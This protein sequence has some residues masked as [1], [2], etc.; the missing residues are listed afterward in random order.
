MVLSS[1][2]KSW[3]KPV[4]V[5]LCAALVISA[6][7]S[8]GLFE[9]APSPQ[10][11]GSLQPPVSN[12][13]SRVQA[14]A[15]ARAARNASLAGQARLL[16]PGLEDFPIVV[17]PGAQGFLDLQTA[18]EFCRRTRNSAMNTVLLDEGTYVG[19]FTLPPSGVT[20][21]GRYGNAATILMGST[22]AGQPTLQFSPSGG[23]A[24]GVSTT[25]SG[26][27]IIGV[28]EAAVDMSATNADAEIN[29]DHCEVQSS[30]PFPGVRVSGGGF[31]SDQ[32]MSCYLMNSTIASAGDGILAN[33][34]P[35]S[36]VFA[37]RSFIRCSATAVTMNSSSTV[38]TELILA[39]TP[40]E[41]TA[42]LVA[43]NIDH[44]FSGASYLSG[45]QIGVDLVGVLDASLERG[46][47][48]SASGS[49]IRVSNSRLHA[50]YLQI[51]PNTAGG[52]GIA[53]NTSSEVN[54]A[55]CEFFSG[56]SSEAIR[57][58]GSSVLFSVYNHW[59]Y[60]PL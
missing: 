51:S 23:A 17:Y 15:S 56:L 40:V 27:T 53:A 7:M 10:A 37:F 22:G 25:L 9:L 58:D 49:A 57:I 33:T 2:L 29:I 48:H 4:L 3:W 38:E 20:V 55:F 13:P 54:A 45:E 50:R 8:H 43:S 59:Q 5:V 41:G 12:P 31:G 34:G 60:S 52:I 18:L 36:L 1:S 46:E 32:W 30:G 35:Y 39:W 14:M 24:G 21:I 42:A 6:G 44:V 19:N 26:L 16:G 47:I 11:S 28:D